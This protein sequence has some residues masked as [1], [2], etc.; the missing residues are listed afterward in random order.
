MKMKKRNEKTLI[1]KKEQT[2]HN[3]ILKSS[4]STPTSDILHQEIQN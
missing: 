2:K 3:S 4:F 1:K